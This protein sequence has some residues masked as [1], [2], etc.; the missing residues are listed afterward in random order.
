VVAVAGPE[1]A[2][3]QG[4]K[5]EALRKDVLEQ[6]AKAAAAMPG[7][8]D[9]ELHRKSKILVTIANDQDR[10]K[11]RAGAAATFK[12]AFEAAGA[13]QAEFLRAE[14]LANVGFYQAHAGFIADAQ[15]CVDGIVVKDDKKAAQMQAQNWRN[16]VLMEMA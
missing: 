14:A 11:D 7:T 1:Q 10:A 5:K 8:K 9:E 13:I 4:Q 15:K 16:H 2:V 6:A 3:E 12:L